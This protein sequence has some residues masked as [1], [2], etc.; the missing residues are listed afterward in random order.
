MVETN[1][2]I[3]LPIYIGVLCSIV[4][5]H[6]LGHFLVAK[7]FGVPVESFGIGFPLPL[8]WIYRN[9]TEGGNTFRPGV[10]AI[11]I[12]SFVRG[13]TRYSLGPILIGGFCGISEDLEDPKSLYNTPKIKRALV[14]LAGPAMNFIFAFL[15]FTSMFSTVPIRNRVELNGAPVVSDQKT[16]MPVTEAV[17][18]GAELMLITTKAS[19]ES[20]PEAAKDPK[21][22]QSIVSVGALVANAATHA[23]GC[24]N[25]SLVLILAGIV[26]ISVGVVNLLPIPALDGGHLFLTGIEALLRKKKLPK[27]IWRLNILGMI[28]L[29]I[30][31]GSLVAN[32]LA[33]P[34]ATLDWRAVFP[35]QI[36][37]P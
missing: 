4:F 32:D 31:F 3:G 27:A 33:N 29:L 23:Y 13:E 36:V 37:C 11:N 26:N 1:W 19:I 14:L 8:P 34:V 20:L 16:T 9:M 7:L 10:K 5:V 22:V 15:L 17:R 18:A 6:E 25:W 28:F 30:I 35:P 21:Q 24:G 2:V 12:C